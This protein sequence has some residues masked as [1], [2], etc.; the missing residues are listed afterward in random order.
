M[1]NRII[2]PINAKVGNV[3]ARIITNGVF[4]VSVSFV[5][6]SVVVCSIDKVML[7]LGI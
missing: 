6:S 7:Q 4:G 2:I 1:T 5:K 3:T